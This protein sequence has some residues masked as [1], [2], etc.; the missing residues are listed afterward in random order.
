MEQLLEDVVW[1]YR[2]DPPPETVLSLSKDQFA[3]GKYVVEYKLFHWVLTQNRCHG[4]APSRTQLMEK[5]QA[6]VPS[7][8][9][10]AVRSQ[11]C[12]LFGGNP[13]AQRKWL[14]RFRK[15]WGVRLGVLKVQDYVPVEEKRA[16]AGG[17]RCVQSALRLAG[18]RTKN[19]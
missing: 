2:S 9:N 4:V 8:V 11:L 18:V 13:R 14:A 1:A 12:K 6:F 16:K 17:C 19:H 3:A 15:R 7:N 10:S 5:A